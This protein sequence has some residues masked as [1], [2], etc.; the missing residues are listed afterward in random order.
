MAKD[1][2]LETVLTKVLNKDAAQNT[3]CELQM[4]SVTDPALRR[5]YESCQ[6]GEA[7]SGTVVQDFIGNIRLC[8]HK[9]SSEFHLEDKY[10]EGTDDKSLSI[11]DKAALNSTPFD[12]GLE[13]VRQP[14][15]AQQDTNFET[16]NLQFFSK[17]GLHTN[18][19]T[20]PRDLVAF[21]E[22]RKWTENVMYLRVPNGTD[23]EDI[24]SYVVQ[25]TAEVYSLIFGDTPF[26]G[27]ANIQEVGV[28]RLSTCAVPGRHNQKVYSSDS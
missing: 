11:E 26:G 8:H 10:A 22:A 21:L 6:Y 14:L 20:E 24:K 28:D 1:K 25:R 17:D 15:M 7:E 27:G 18:Q 23:I 4:I 13:M 12:Q 3:R 2:E 16:Y 5:V 9:Y 19:D